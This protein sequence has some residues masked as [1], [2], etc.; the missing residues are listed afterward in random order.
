MLIEDLVAALGAQRVDVSEQ[1]RWAY[2]KDLTEAEP[3]MPDVVVKV[4]SVEQ[5]QTVLRLSRQ[6][7]VPITPIVG[8]FNMSALAIPECGGIV[9]D[10]GRM[11]RILEV[12]EEDLYM[13]IEPGVTWEQVSRELAEHH[14]SLRFGYST[15]PPN[16]SVLAN[17]LLDGQTNLSLRYGSTGQWVNGVEVVLADGEIVRTGSGAFGVSWCAGPPMPNLT[18]LFI[19]AHGITGIVTKMSIQLFS[20]RRY[21]QRYLLPAFDESILCD[22][23]AK[24]AH[25]DLCDDLAGFSWPL[26]K[27]ALGASPGTTPDPGEPTFYCIIDFSSND[28]AELSMK[29][30]R[31][32]RLLKGYDRAFAGLMDVE[33][34][35]DTFPQ[36][37]KLLE[38]P[39]RVDFLLDYP[40]GGM[41]FIGAY[42]PTSKWSRAITAGMNTLASH[43][44]T[45]IVLL[46][47]MWG[48]HYNLIHHLVLFNRDSEEERRRVR[49]V[50]EKICEGLLDLGFVPYKTP[51]WVL[52]RFASR[53][54]PGFRKLQHQIKI[55]LDPDGLLN[56]GK[57]LT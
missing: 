55:T 23:L 9:L 22:F 46:R 8:G 11:N 56:P 20:A 25:E 36:L 3:R 27:M 26:P 16:T 21:R 13:V 43:N 17:G 18:G 33:S 34:T 41:S 28:R 1:T 29:D 42:G 54:D 19:N 30:R 44:Y 47:P 35:V 2:A 32:H 7:K 45:P 24:T 37:K 51:A 39:A 57:W 10:L 50:N 49:T 4:D 38:L 6:Y 31:I 5:V 53:L 14:P 15:A 52:R 40:G 48:G 12:N